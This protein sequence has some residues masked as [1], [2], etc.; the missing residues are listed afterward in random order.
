[1]PGAK[2]G[3]RSPRSVNY[4]TGPR[5]GGAEGGLVGGPEVVPELGARLVGLGQAAA[6]LQDDGV[7][8]RTGQML[9][10]MAEVQSGDGAAEQR[11]PQR[12]LLAG[13]QVGQ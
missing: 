4:R 9:P 7:D 6:A 2:F 3:G 1:M 13:R 5:K 8:Q 11:V 10:A 12:A